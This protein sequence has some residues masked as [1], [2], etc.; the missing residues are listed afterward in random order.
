MISSSGSSGSGATSTDT[1]DNGTLSL[2]SETGEVSVDI[3]VGLSVD[4]SLTFEE[5]R[6]YFSIDL[7]AAEAAGEDIVKDKNTLIITRGDLVLRI[8]F[9][10]YKV[11][12]DITSGEIESISLS[13][14]PVGND[15]GG[16]GWLVMDMN[17]IP[18]DASMILSVSNDFDKDTIDQI[19]K[20]SGTGRKID[21]A[22]LMF[23]VERKNLEEGIDIASTTVYMSVPEEWVNGHGGA[24][25]VRIV[26]VTA[27]GKA[28]VGTPVIAGNED[29]SYT[30]SMVSGEGVSEYV[31]ATLSDASVSGSPTGTIAS[32]PTPGATATQA[33][34]SPVMPL[35]AVLSVACAAMIIKIS[36]RD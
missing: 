34:G 4:S 24:E 16:E 14:V 26:Q 11:R 3:T 25:K 35:L 31:L 22:A 7:D 8:K 5:G 17:S 21:S 12:N 36:R 9:V 18:V 2:N 1:A 10:D 23:E 33:A 29:G 30:F 28:V 6:M 13:T 27:D 32:T 15:P 19:M 20:D